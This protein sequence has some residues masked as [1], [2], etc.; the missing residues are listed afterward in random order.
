MR[1]AFHIL[2]QR[3]AFKKPSVCAVVPLSL[4]VLISDL[5]W[6]SS[7]W[8]LVTALPVHHQRDPEHMF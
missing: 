4:L 7:A 8:S 6:Y 1:R 2:A 5:S 3:L